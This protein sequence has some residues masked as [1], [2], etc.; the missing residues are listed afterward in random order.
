VSDDAEK[1]A[2]TMAEVGKLTASIIPVAINLAR[3]HA[4]IVLGADA[5]KGLVDHAAHRIVSLALVTNGFLMSERTESPEDVEECIAANIMMAKQLLLV[6][7]KGRK[8]S[9][10]DEDEKP[11][12]DATPAWLDNETLKRMFEES[13]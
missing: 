10:S 7:K 3:R 9:G 4:R 13:N 1:M 12:P 2:E 6:G 11:E 5:P 8:P